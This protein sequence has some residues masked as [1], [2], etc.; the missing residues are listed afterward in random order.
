[1][2]DAQRGR[3]RVLGCVGG[4]QEGTRRVWGLHKGVH[5]GE[6]VCTQRVQG[7]HEAHPGG[8]TGSGQDAVGVLRGS[9]RCPEECSA[10]Q[11]MSPVQDPHT[12]IGV[13]DTAGD[14]PGVLPSTKQPS[15]SLQHFPGCPKRAD[16]K[17]WA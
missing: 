15:A 7:V 17:S 13:Q 1:M 16:S 12:G 2:G 8:C 5:R 14:T 11:G 9:G 3:V 6:G 4:A 10:L